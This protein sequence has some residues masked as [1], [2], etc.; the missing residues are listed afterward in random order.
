MSSY[1]MLRRFMDAACQSATRNE[2]EG[3]LCNAGASNPRD[4][5]NY[6][7]R[8]ALMSLDVLALVPEGHPARQAFKEK[9]YI[10]CAKQ[11]LWYLAFTHAGVE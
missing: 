10:N 1:P 3:D 5:V 4:S 8:K 9:M 2:L 7:V 11:I 6:A